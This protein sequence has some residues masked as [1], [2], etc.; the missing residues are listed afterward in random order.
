MIYMLNPEIFDY[1][2]DRPAVDFALDVFPALLD[3]DVPFHVHE[4][5]AYWNDVGSLPE[6]LQGNLDALRG[7]VRV[8]LEGELLEQ[9]GG[10][11]AVETGEPGVS[12]RVLVADGCRIDPAARLD[13][14]LV[15]G[16]GS[17]IRAG[18]R[19]K[20]SVVLSGADVPEG[21]LVAGAVYGRRT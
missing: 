9:S 8:E 12:G 4:I 1:F 14:P 3:H 16:R 11:A 7:R 6:Y 5:D 20:E 18:S 15:I 21:S 19:V 2:P 17:T 10:D 13:G